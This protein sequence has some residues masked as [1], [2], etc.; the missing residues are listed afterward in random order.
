[1]GRA[2]VPGRGPQQARGEGIR[3]C[4][5]RGAA[6]GTRERGAGEAVGFRQLRPAAQ[7]PAAGTQSQ[8]RR[9]NSDFRAP[10]GDLPSGPEAEGA[11]RELCWIRE[12]ITN[13]PPSLPSDT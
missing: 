8:D 11:S 10:G 7:E 12:T 9:G 1:N 6:R 4:V 2:S 5:L 13:F 3:R